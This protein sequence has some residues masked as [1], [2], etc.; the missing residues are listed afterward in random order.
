MPRFIFLVMV[1]LTV[2][3]PTI[4]VIASGLPIALPATGQVIKYVTSDDGDLKKGLVA[5]PRFGVNSDGTVAD[6]LT[7]LSWAPS[8]NLIP[9][10]DATFDKDGTANDGMVSWQHT[11]DFVAKLNLMNSGAGYLNHNDWRLPNVTELRNLLD[12]SKN[13]PAL[14][15]GHP[16]TSVA[17][18]GYWSSTSYEA[19]HSQAWYVDMSSG[20]I[21]VAGKASNYYLIP[22]RGGVNTFYGTDST[23][24]QI[25]SF[26]MPA[27][28]TGLTVP[29]TEIGYLDNGDVTGYWLSEN[30]TPPVAGASG[31]LEYQPTRFTFAAA[32]TDAVYLFIKDAAGNVSAVASV[33]VTVTAAGGYRNDLR[34][35]LPATGQT[36][37]YATGDDGALTRG[38]K[39]PLPRFLVNQTLDMVEDSVTGFMWPRNFNLIPT[40]DATF[41]K[42]GTANDGLVTWQHALDFV[43][44][45]NTTKYLGYS[46][47]RLPDVTELRSILDLSHTGPALSYA[48]PFLNVANSPYWSSTSYEADHSQAWYVD[49]NTGNVNVTAKNGSYYLVPVRGGLN[50][51]YGS[52]DASKPTITSFTMPGTFTGLTVPITQIGYLDN[53]DITGYWLSESSTPPAAGANGWFEYQPIRFTFAAV[54][55]DTLYLFIKDAGGNVSSAA[56]ATVTVTA[57]SGYRGDPR[58]DL[59]AT[60]QTTSYATGDDGSVARGVKWPLPRFLV[61][62][63]FDMVEDSVTGFMWSRNFNLIP[64]FD[65]TFDKDGAANDG[66][67]TWQHALDFVANL[68]SAKYLGYS[69]WRLPNITELR[70][71]LDLSRTSPALPYAQP[72]L[73]VA[74]SSYWSSTTYEA[75]HS[76][77]WYVDMNTGNVNVT[78]KNGSYYLSQTIILHQKTAENS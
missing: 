76:Q 71:I 52:T 61:N 64:T 78:P 14:P 42:D 39:W 53:G 31:W 69:D 27:T 77:A 44:N 56:S 66:Q 13:A 40:V 36:A 8:F 35:D 6:N 23:K 1:V 10:V 3:L 51:F 58:S 26:T 11:L 65:A 12:L 43:V 70:S 45:L 25:T 18:N 59:A 48:Q 20:N 29:I 73:N 21:S 37:S 41:D 2:L 75:D 63:T 30:N 55:T 4:P 72:F 38:V 57:A 9:T 24:P 22:V 50:T 47:W 49:M 32:G 17:N 19:D 15:A 68:N 33:A 34:S 62:Q 54:G 46:D 74:N 28:W 60:G 7:G 5:T 16:F 67:V